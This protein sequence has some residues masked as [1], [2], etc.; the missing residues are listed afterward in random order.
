MLWPKKNSHKMITK[1]N[2]EA[3]KFPS[4]HNFSNGPSLNKF[5][6]EASS[7]VSSACTREKTSGTQSTWQQIIP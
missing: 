7:L 5:F 3:R 1:K 4:P 2:P 6:L